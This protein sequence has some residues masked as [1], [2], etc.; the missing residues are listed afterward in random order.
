MKIFKFIKKYIFKYKLQ[1][2]IFFILSILSWI[3]SIS[4][5]YIT[6]NYIDSLIYSQ[7]SSTIFNF[8]MK[9]LLIGIVSIVSS[10]IMNYSYVKLQ[11][12]SAIDL[13]LDVLNHIFKLPILYFKDIDTTYLNQRVNSD[14]NTLVS[15]ILNNMLDSI[16]KSLTLIFVFYISI[17][18]NRKLTILLIPFI[19]LYLAIYFIFKKPLFKS[20]HDLKEKQNKFFSK[21]NEQLYNIKLIKLNSTFE[22]SGEQL[23]ENFST[24]LVSLLKYT[25]ISYIFS[26]SDSMTVTIYQITIFLF[27][28]ME[29]INGGLT[30][31]QFTIIN[32]Y[33]S[34]IME[35]I[36]YYL[37]LGKSYQDALVSYNR[38]EKILNQSK[39]ANGDKTLDTIDT[40]ILENVY[41][42]YDYTRNIINDFN[43]E[44]KKGSIYCITGRNGTGKSTFINLILGLFNDYYKGNIYYNSLELRK[45]DMYS[46]RK[47]IIGISEQEPRLINDT[48]KKNVVYGINKYNYGDIEELLKKLNF[49]LN[50][51]SK[52]INTSLYEDANNISGGE[53]LK[54]SL[55]RTFLK[56]PDVIILDEPT[57]VLDINSIE[58]LKFI[59]N[60][61]KEYKIIIIVTHSKEIL[62]IADEVISSNE[63]CY[64]LNDKI[65]VYQ[66]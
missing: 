62:D 3:I 30:I 33:F 28:G 46:V 4:I 54:I 56:D 40:I 25:R 66:S 20:G 47:R 26:S 27:G 2:F 13:N 15:F 64:N 9:I 35:C 53:K 37:S 16:I 1:L 39:E 22:E 21:M 61:I 14:S 18:I 50:K 55:T 48:I 45:L 34:M 60:Q 8:T 19:P 24:V 38:L 49:D 51:F 58:K 63:I 57:S 65:N 23:R 17:R 12:K 29:I 36:S 41:F 10:F 7:N 31:G 32:S 43:Y 11:T 5:P 59:L 52:G 6:G 42:S 44:F